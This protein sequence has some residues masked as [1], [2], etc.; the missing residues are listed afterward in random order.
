MSDQ[1]EI[2]QLAAELADLKAALGAT[3]LRATTAETALA[4]A[5]EQLASTKAALDQAEAQTAAAN[6]NR[7][8]AV[9]EAAEMRRQAAL[10]DA[11]RQAAELAADEA[12]ADRLAAQQ[13]AA[14]ANADRDKAIADR[15]SF[16][17]KIAQFQA[18]LAAA[19]SQARTMVDEAV[20]AERA[21][22]AQV[23]IAANAATA[24]AASDRD[25]LAAKFDKLMGDPVE[26]G[27]VIAQIYRTEDNTAHDT[28]AAAR[29]HLAGARLGVSAAEAKRLGAVAK[30]NPAAI[31]TLMEAS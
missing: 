18:D 25:A 23:L 14:V 13:Q 30:D 24:K 9:A 8:N 12:N 11:A 10:A 26:P 3:Q 2:A 5:A 28:L 6:N 31:A 21:S 1:R 17:G 19:R 29:L 27:I 7:D 20:Q 15:D 4:S 22:A 16:A